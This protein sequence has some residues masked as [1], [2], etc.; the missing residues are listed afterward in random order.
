MKR[1]STG[2]S[3]IMAIGLDIFFRLASG[4]DELVFA[5]YYEGILLRYRVGD[6]LTSD[7]GFRSGNLAIAI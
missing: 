7:R 5:N 2:F 3:M 6:L 4:I 1:T